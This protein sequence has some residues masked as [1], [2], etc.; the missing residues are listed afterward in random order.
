MIVSS[1]DRRGG[2]G[3]VAQAANA[4]HVRRA[5]EIAA[6]ARFGRAAAQG[7]AAQM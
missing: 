1:R 4:V 6:V 5:C 2:L 3:T 7:G